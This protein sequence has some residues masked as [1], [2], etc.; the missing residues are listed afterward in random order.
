MPHVSA[1]YL[2]CPES[3]GIQSSVFDRL[4]LCVWETNMPATEELA[5]L[6]KDM[7]ETQKETTAA[8]TTAT[9]CC[10]RTVGGDQEGSAEAGGGKDSGF[11]KERE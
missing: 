7:Q 6:L 9:E 8:V 5:G 4:Q 11:Y 1:L 2:R 10:S 3:A